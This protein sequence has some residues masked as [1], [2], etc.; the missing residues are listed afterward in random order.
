MEEQMKSLWA[1]PYEDP[2]VRNV[3]TGREH[4]W[5]YSPDFL[6]A[7]QYTLKL[8]GSRY[9]DCAAAN[10]RNNQSSLGGSPPDGFTWHHCYNP[11]MDQSRGYVMQL[12]PRDLHRKCCPHVGAFKQGIEMGFY[13]GTEDRST[14]EVKTGQA[15]LRAVSHHKSIIKIAIQVLEEKLQLCLPLSL[16]DFY[17]RYALRAQD[18]TNHYPDRTIHYRNGKDIYDICWFE[19]IIEG[20]SSILEILN[21]E[22]YGRNN[23]TGGLD[24]G[25]KSNIPFAEDAFGNVYYLSVEEAGRRLVDAPVY[26]YNHEENS[27]VKVAEA[28][29]DFQS[30]WYTTA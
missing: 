16:I 27:S 25:Q 24:F 23:L 29:E 20:S 14:I 6:N 4:Q 10:E 19:E 15:F 26:F 18:K 17:I 9:K 3:N 11:G 12:A 8:T 22:R 2:D 1:E 7:V 28:F 5:R 13:S 30:G 21:Y